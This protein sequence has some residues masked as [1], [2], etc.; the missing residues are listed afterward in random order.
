MDETGGSGHPNRDSVPI[1]NAFDKYGSA[2][3][4][5]RGM[6]NRFF[7]DLDACLPAAAPTTVLEVGM[8]EAE[9]A[10]RLRSRWPAARV[11]GI[12]LPSSDLGAHWRGAG[13]PGCFADIAQLPFPDASFDLVLAIE[14]FEHLTEPGESLRELRRVGRA[15]FVLSVPR[16]PV[17]RM[18][19]LARG[20]YVAALGNT[21]GHLQHWSRRAFAEL[22]GR[23]LRVEQVRSPFP[24][25][26]VA[27]H[28]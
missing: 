12:D 2:N 4:L 22:V 24:W 18:A 7:T 6:M 5:V 15:D 1:G 28:A 11:V 16:E 21:P 13:V 8:G 25:T 17:W 14:V 10:G 26:M 27:A 20:R 19:N 3:P 9:V 23:E